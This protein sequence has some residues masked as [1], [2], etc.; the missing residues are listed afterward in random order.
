MRLSLFAAWALA[1]LWGCSLSLENPEDDARKKLQRIYPTSLEAMLGRWV[2]DST[3]TIDDINASFLDNF[4]EIF[5]DTTLNARDTARQVFPGRLDLRFGL[6][7]DTLILPPRPGHAA[8]DTFLVKLRFLGNWLELYHPP[9]SRY[10]FF[11]KLKFPDTSTW[12]TLLADTLWRQEAR[13]ITPDTVVRMAF[14]KDFDYLRFSGDS[15]YWDQRRE[16]LRVVRGGPL[17]RAGKTWTWSPAGAARLFYAEVV[18]RDSLQLWPLTSGRPD[19]GYFLFRKNG[20]HAFD[21]DMTPWLGYLRTDSIGF[22]GGFQETHFGR[23]YDLE[24]GADHSVRTISTMGALPVYQTWSI[25]TGTLQLL[26]PGTGTTSLR[27]RKLDD[28]L[29]ILT[30]EDG[31]GLAKSTALYLTQV[32]G[33]R[34]PA[35]PLERFPKGNYLRLTL[36]MDTLDYFFHAN[37]RKNTWDEHE[38][39]RV[40]SQDTLWMALRLDAATESFSSD[41]NGFFFIFQGRSPSLGRFTCK[42]RPQKELTLRVSRADS[43]RPEGTIQGACLITASQSPPPPDSTLAVTGEFRLR[44]LAVGPLLAPQWSQP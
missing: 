39:A 6:V 37:Y 28:K 35:H 27:L 23:Y 7:G 9:E 21:L 36:G 42:G 8:P 19:S 11:H 22:A 14:R 10:S 31:P 17:L 24:L 20:I 1:F 26:A 41:Q 30:A 12:D 33:S 15:L 5:P 38:I 40:T 13:R 44:R 32:D 16:G 43:F 34:Y 2:G 3:Y 4:L 25:D 18:S 29:L